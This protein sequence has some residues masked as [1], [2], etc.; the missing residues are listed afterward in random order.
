MTTTAHT[1]WRVGYSD[2]SGMGEDGE[3]PTI[4]GVDD[5]CICSGSRDSWGVPQGMKAHH[6]QLA[7]LCVNACEGIPDPTSLRRQRDELLRALERIAHAQPRPTRHGRDLYRGDAHR[8]LQRIARN[9]IA[10]ARG[11]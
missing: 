1:P 7:I 5:E 4:V 9:A 6:A 2:G 3:N 11:E 10:N 8:S